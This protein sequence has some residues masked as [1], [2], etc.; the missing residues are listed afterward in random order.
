MP[1]KN[2]T[3]SFLFQ[4]AL[5]QYV[6]GVLELFGYLF[7]FVGLVLFDFDFIIESTLSVADLVIDFADQRLVDG[8]LLTDFFQRLLLVF[9]NVFGLICPVVL[10]KDRYL[11]LFLFGDAW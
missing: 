11:C 3:V 8:S 2:K 5:L 6:M 4:E 1:D 9:G 10:V 7:L